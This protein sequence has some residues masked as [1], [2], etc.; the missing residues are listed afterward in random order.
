MNE[1]M[2][3]KLDRFVYRER[4]RHNRWVYY[5]RQGKG[6]RI[7]MPD[8]FTETEA[9]EAAYRAARDSVEPK[10]R[11]LGKPGTLEWL[12]G[13]YRTNTAYINGF[14]V[15]TRRQRDN[16]YKGVIAKSGGIDYRRVT[17]AKI[18]DGIEKRSATPAQA[19]NFLDAMKGLFRWALAHQYVKA[20]PTAGLSNPKRLKG[21]G[22]A[23]WTDKDVAAYEERWPLGTKERVWLSVLLYTGLRRGDAVRLGRQHLKDGMHT[24]DTEKNGMTVFIPVF[25]ALV[26]ALGRGPT[27]DLTYVCGD[28]GKPLK[29]ESFGNYFRLAC[30]EAG[31]GKSAHGLRKLA[32]SRA[33]EHGLSV[34]ELESMFGWT[35]GTMASFYTKKADRKRLA[36]SAAG[37]MGNATRPHLEME[38]PAPKK[39]TN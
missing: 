24:I 5:F 6:R 29:K 33:A 12:V 25:D 1:D 4:T 38:S 16:I 34:A 15:A 26:E 39:I 20:D 22:F 13:Q 11:T 17:R 19:R 2:P 8:P 27:S 3:R 9:Y 32:A 30:Q 14:S 18:L 37:K 10:A 7:R 28:G 23:A 35:G 36:I 21:E 31:V